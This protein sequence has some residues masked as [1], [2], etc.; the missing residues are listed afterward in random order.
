MTMWTKLYNWFKDL[1]TPNWLRKLTE[2]LT[3]NILYPV[4]EAIK[5]EGID[6]LKRLIV[7]AAN[8]PDLNPTQKARWVYREF[9]EGFGKD[10]TSSA[11][12]L[13]IELLVSQLKKQGII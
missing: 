5:D 6:T 7:K 12:N 2:Y 8:M 1:G 10:I 3:F 11:I 9:K 4:L 13:A